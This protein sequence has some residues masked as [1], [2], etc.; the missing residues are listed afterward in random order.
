MLSVDPGEGTKWNLDAKVTLYYATGKSKMPQVTGLQKAAA[1]T[2]LRNAGF[3]KSPTIKTQE[4][5]S[6]S[7]GEVFKQSPDAF[8]TVKRTTAITLWVAV[9]PTE[10]TP[11]T[12]STTPATS[13]TSTSTGG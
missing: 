2:A 1:I 12:E 9:A 13:P 7:P 4:T 11:P 5:S 8:A 3:T 10:P 6:Y